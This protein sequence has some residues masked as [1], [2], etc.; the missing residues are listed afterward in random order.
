MAIDLLVQ[1]AVSLIR[2]LAAIVLSAGALYSGISLLDRL[3]SSIDEWKEIRKGNAALGILFASVVI[4]VFLLTESRISD[5][6]FSVSWGFDPVLVAKI[7][8]ITFIN[9]LLGIFASLIIIFL[10]INVIDRI[11]P[12]LDELAE[13]KKGNLAVAILLSVSIVLVVLAVRSPLEA[14][15]GILKGIESALL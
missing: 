5:F 7:L 8:A 10:T 9:Y 1:L 11:T 12:D 13:L 6:V 14:A 15:F 2:M 3:T 4:S